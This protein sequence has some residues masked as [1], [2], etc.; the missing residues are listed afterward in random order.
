MVQDDVQASTIASPQTGSKPEPR[1]SVATAIGDEQRQ[2][3]QPLPRA[4]MV[5]IQSGQ[6]L[7]L[8]V[9]GVYK[10]ALV[11]ACSPANCADMC[12]GA[13]SVPSQSPHDAHVSLSPVSARCMAFRH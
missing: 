5:E 13:C 12:S 9:C 3:P 11:A 8:C 2:D 1:L 6:T 4:A 10:R 7:E